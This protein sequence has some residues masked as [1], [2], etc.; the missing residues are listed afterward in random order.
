MIVCDVARLLAYGSVPLAYALGRIAM[1]QLYVVAFVAGVALVF[2][3]AA[4][5]AS[6]PRVV[7]VAQLPRAVSLN[8]TLEAAAYLLG[9]GMAGVLIGLASGVVAGAALAYLVDS[10]SYLAS[11]LSLGAIR[12]PLQPERDAVPVPSAGRALGMEIADGLRC[13]W[14]H[15]RLR[16]IALLTMAMNLFDGP[17]M[18]AVIVL[19]RDTLRV[20]ASTVGLIFALAG[21]GGVLGSFV[22]PWVVAHLHV[23]RAIIGAFAVWALAMSLEA[24]AVAPP[25]LIAGAVLADMMISLYDVAQ[26][27]YRLP[28]IPHELQGCVNSAYRLPSYAG[29]LVGTAAGGVLLGLLGPRPVLW[30]IAAGL[31][32]CTV[33]AGLSPL[34]RA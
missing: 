33:G 18:L 1:A 21:V 7:P 4:E 13:L 9:P 34:R 16:A 20:D 10:L 15:P 23:G 12:R 28:L 3:D 24:A 27:S 11:M 14:R 32:A 17:L 30:L 6:L 22:A 31:G 8:A 2:F 29:G 19:A 26:M 25:M 5:L